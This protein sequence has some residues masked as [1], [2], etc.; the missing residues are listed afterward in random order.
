MFCRC[1]DW[2][3]DFKLKLCVLTRHICAEDQPSPSIDCTDFRTAGNVRAHA[4]AGVLMRFM[5]W[6]SIRHC[7]E[8]QRS[9]STVNHLNLYLY[10]TLVRLAA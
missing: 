3:G 8:H 10:R 6:M 7:S 4:D 1:G 5:L 2:S 9:S